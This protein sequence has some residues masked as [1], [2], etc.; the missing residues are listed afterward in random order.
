MLLDWVGIMLNQFS[1][2]VK[3]LASD[4]STPES[5]DWR[6]R[7]IE[8]AGEGV[9]ITDP[10]LPDNPII[11]VNEGFRKITGYTNDDVLGRNCRFMR[12]P[13]T[14]PKTNAEMRSRLAAA[15]SVSCEV[16]NYRKNREPFWN[17][18]FISPVFD[19]N[20]T[21]THFVGIQFDITE[22]KAAEAVAERA[23]EQLAATARFE[24]LA[25]LA[26]GLA[27][28]INN[29]TTGM[30]LL[31]AHQRRSLQRWQDKP[32]TS[33]ELSAAE[34]TL[35]KIEGLCARVS[36]V[37]AAM[38]GFVAHPR[39]AELQVVQASELIHGALNPF[40]ERIAATGV[41]IEL[42]VHGDLMVASESRLLVQ[43]FAALI[44]NSL[45]ATESLPVKQLFIQSVAKDGALFF[46]FC[47]SAPLL[48]SQD[49]NKLF[50]P[51]FTTKQ[52]GKG[53]GLGLY[54]ARNIC[55]RIGAKIFYEREDD[56][57][58]FVVALPITGQK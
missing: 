22:V 34:V 51:F 6:M 49:A 57:N 3:N 37:V 38:Q 47:D 21:L 31:C 45:D 25:Q 44:G 39:E 20:Q 27:H 43:V 35:T 18:L 1:G 54:V 26:S 46:R 52:Q 55:E 4:L 10:R 13:E 19:E 42:T 14:N 30:L 15:Q 12:G 9:V 40:R 48:S 29:P 41:A 24:A 58:V 5:L 7:A 36:H 53:T 28:E 16:L 32:P 23:R 17:R 8:A 56:K 11:Y 33:E 50:M 2:L